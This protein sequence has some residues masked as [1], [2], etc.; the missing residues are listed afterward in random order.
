[1]ELFESAKKAADAATG[2]GVSSSGPEV[3]RCVDAL[4][5]LKSYPVT[6]EALASTQV[7]LGI[8]ILI[9]L[10]FRILFDL[11]RKFCNSWFSY[12]FVVSEC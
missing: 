12:M 7:W 9:Y 1:M 8:S 11:I 5:Q 10:F 6:Y 2:D 4:K 3:G